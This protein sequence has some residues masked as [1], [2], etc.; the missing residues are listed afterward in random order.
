MRSI[1]LD[2]QEITEMMKSKEQDAVT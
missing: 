2:E 1:A